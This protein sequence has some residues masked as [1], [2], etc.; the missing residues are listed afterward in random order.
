MAEWQED[1]KNVNRA[2]GEF[3]PQLLDQALRLLENDALYRA[4]KVIGPAKWLRDLHTRRDAAKGR[5]A[6]NN[7][8][9]LAVAQAPA[10]FAHPRSSMVG[11]LLV[12][13]AEGK[14]FNEVARSFAAKM[15][16]TQYQRPTAAPTDGAI[17]KAEQI[18]ETLGL[19]PSLRRRFAKPVD[20]PVSALLWAEAAY[21][22]ESSK[23]G[24]FGHLKSSQPPPAMTL[25]EKVMTWDKFR[26][27]ALPKALKLEVYVRPIDQ[28]MALLTAV[29]PDAPPILQWDRPEHVTRSAGMS[30]SAG[31]LA[32][33]LVCPRTPGPMS[34]SSPT[35]PACGATPAIAS[36]ASVVVSSSGSRALRRR[37]IPAPASSPRSSSLSCTRFVQLSRPSQSARSS[38]VRG[39]AWLPVFW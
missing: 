23:D 12:D 20:V 4:E 16:P 17:A 26:R 11:T 7:V 3:K 18:F 35:S 24:L 22:P 31:Q 6:R 13:L 9:W 34:T 15:N 10:G 27:E 25:P 19:G 37:A 28:F 39:L 5:E 32:S 29:N 1:Y 8:V 30:G 21:K 33:S 38:R 14:D 2:L 36:A